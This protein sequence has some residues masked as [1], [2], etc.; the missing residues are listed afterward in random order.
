[1]PGG[2]VEHM[3]SVEL[4]LKREVLEETGAS[5]KIRRFLGCFEHSF[6]LSHNSTC[7][8][9]EY[10][11]IF[12]VESEFLKRDIKIPQL[13][14]HIKLFWQPIVNL[15]DLDFRPKPLKNI[16]FKWLEL[17]LGNTLYSQ[18]L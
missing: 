2:H 10:N 7:H 11:F 13:E 8:N 15:A 5:C 4:T 1:M 18:M 6:E 17:D 14:S 12:L 16:L 3:A 9:H